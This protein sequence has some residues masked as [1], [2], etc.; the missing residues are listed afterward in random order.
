[1]KVPSTINKKKQILNH[2]SAKMWV[3]YMTENIYSA[4]LYI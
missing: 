4:M 2:V 3:D 1:M